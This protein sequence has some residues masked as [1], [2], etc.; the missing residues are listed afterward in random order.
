MLFEKYTNRERKMTISFVSIQRSGISGW[1][2]VQKNFSGTC[3][4]GVSAEVLDR[5]FVSKK[6]TEAAAKTMANLKG[7]VFVPENTNVITMAS[8]NK[9]F[10]VVELT[11]SGEVI[12]RG[13]ALQNQY[14]VLV[15]A[16][17]YARSKNFPC[18]LPRVT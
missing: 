16:I 7:L 11:S 5:R 14:A 4:A 9:R 13:V 18:I 15:E 17:E 12:D 1:D 8:L 10:L 3:G 2:V 6:T